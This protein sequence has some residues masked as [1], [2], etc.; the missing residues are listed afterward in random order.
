MN[1]KVDNP[2]LLKPLD[3]L[4][5]PESGK[6]AASS[7]KHKTKDGVV[8]FRASPESGVWEQWHLGAGR[9]PEFLPADITAS[10]QG[11]RVVVLPSETL[12][13]WPLWIASTGD[14]ADLVR[15]ELSGRHLLKRGMESSLV[16]LPILTREERQ[17]VLAVTVEEPFPEEGMPD[18][19][20]SAD[21]FELPARLLADSDGTEL[22]L[23]Q[24]W[25]NLQGALYRGGQPVWFCGIR[26]EG[27]SDTLRR[28]T[29]RLLAEGILEHSPSL[30]RIE[31]MNEERVERCISELSRAFPGASI[32][33]PSS[34]SWK[35]LPPPI[36]RKD[37]FDLPPSEAR[38]ERSRLKKQTRFL[39]FAT[40]GIVLYLILLLWCAGD[41]LVRKTALKRLRHEITLIEKPALLAKR[42]SERWQAL[43]PAVDP[44]RYALDLLAAVAEPTRGGKVR[45]TRFSLEPGR[46]QLSGEATD[47]PQAYGFIEQLKKNP[48][49]QEYDWHAGQP[50]L[51]GKNSVR[52]DM[53]GIQPDAKPSS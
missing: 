50:Q 34:H 46:L 35:R 38:S 14:S 25:E 2:A 3:H 31:G 36:L 30:I 26:E 37:S 8:V 9:E 43:R 32:R 11:R 23:W 42:D 47:V 6:K 41:L 48:L 45:L 40:V 16:V 13:A 39:S 24:E 10:S 28:I 5:R 49:L 33:A 20:R 44:M 53:E 22:V 15:L 17:L 18:K 7:S 4:S 51:A 27:L 1:L 19:W 52:F 12:F 21:T 29:L